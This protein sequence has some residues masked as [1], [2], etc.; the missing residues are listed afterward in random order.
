MKK[1]LSFFGFALMV[2]GL[3]CVS[4]GD[5]ADDDVSELDVIKPTIEVNVPTTDEVQK[6]EVGSQ[7]EFKG[8]FTDDVALKE[9]TFSIAMKANDAG[10]E[11]ETNWLPES[12][13][14]SL[15]GDM[16]AFD[17]N[18]ALSLFEAI[19]ANTTLGEY[20]LTI[21]LTD[22]A[23]NEADET[24]IVIEIVAASTEA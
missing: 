8:T 2:I 4:C 20:E 19:P 6:Y 5:D 16:V 15:K 18:V 3:T 1:F 11:V 14:E 9:A 12:V 22:E 10:E 23:G 7:I 21:N 17:D 13:V 24:V